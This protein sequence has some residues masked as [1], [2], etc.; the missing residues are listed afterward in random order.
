MRRATIL[1]TL[2]LL[3]LAVAGV[4]SAREGAFVGLLGD[5]EIASEPTEATQPL[6]S[7][8]T[9]HEATVIEETTVTAHP[10]TAVPDDAD[11][12]DESVEDPGRP[13]SDAGKIEREP[14]K[15]PASEDKKIGKPTAGEKPAGKGESAER[16]LSHRQD[17]ARPDKAR[18]KA[19]TG[20]A[21]GQPKATVCH[22]GKT[23]TIGA[24]AKPA[25]LRHGDSL[26]ACAG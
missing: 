21:G 19:E 9:T 18:G 15:A 8:T 17:N 10:E 5:E 14:G 3:M 6:V 12:P 13:N 4:S 23:L 7:G 20:K 25:H 2:A 1:I 26:G 22:R 11:E 16:G 24:P